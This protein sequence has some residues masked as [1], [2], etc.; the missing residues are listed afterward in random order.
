MTDQLDLEDAIAATRQPP[1]VAQYAERRGIEEWR[2]RKAIADG[3]LTVARDVRPMT[4]TGGEMPHTTREWQAK[5]APAVNRI[6]SSVRSFS[7]DGR[8]F[9]VLTED[10]RVVSFR[11]PLTAIGAR[12]QIREIDLLKCKRIQPETAA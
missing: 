6:R 4:V 10:G 11:L 2:V 1:T 12:S 7:A 8:L 3:Q 5:I 9:Y